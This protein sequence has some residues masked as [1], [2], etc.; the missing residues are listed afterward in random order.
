VKFYPGI[1]RG[2]PPIDLTGFPVAFAAP[3]LSKSKAAFPKL[4]LWESLCIKNF[5]KQRYPIIF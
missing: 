5:Y 4:Q 1:F 3:F 2:K